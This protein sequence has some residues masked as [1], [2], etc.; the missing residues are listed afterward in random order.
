MIISRYG[1]NS[2]RIVFGNAIDLD[3]HRLVRKCFQFLADQQYPFILDIIPAFCSCVVL[4]DDDLI[5]FDELSSLLMEKKEAMLS[6][7]LPEPVIHEIAV[8]YGGEWGPDL[9]FVC[10]HT[11]L[12]RDEVIA[13]HTGTLYTVFAVGFIP[14]FSYLGPL[15]HRLYVPRLKTPRVK[16]PAGSVGIALNQTGIY[17][18][19]S[20]GGWQLIGWTGIKLFDKDQAPYS[21]LKMGDR[22]R[23]IRE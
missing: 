4:F 9:D 15:N 14:G 16:V 7:Y 11:G 2:I 21:R 10:S 3:V 17:P 19:D 8:C 12:S 5:C 20:P 23:F 18:F 22:V 1:E 6:A 13:Q